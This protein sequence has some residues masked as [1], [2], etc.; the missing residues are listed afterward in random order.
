MK[1]SIGA[2]VGL[3]VC[4][5]TSSGRAQQ[6]ASRIEVL[7]V[8][9]NFYLL[10]SAVSNVGVQIGLDGVVVVNAGTQIAKYSAPSAAGVL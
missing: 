6:D 8:R 9:P 3:L 5:W 2:L 4:S 1:A 10:A 7:Q